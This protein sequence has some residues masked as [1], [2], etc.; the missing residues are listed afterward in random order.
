MRFLAGADGRAVS[1]HVEEAFP[2]RRGVRHRESGWFSTMVEWHTPVD[3]TYMYCHR[4]VYVF[5][6]LN[7]RI[8]THFGIV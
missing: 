3:R 6:E 7:T 8:S 4:S 2:Q 1:N 5:V